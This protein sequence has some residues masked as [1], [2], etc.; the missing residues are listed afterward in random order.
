MGDTCCAC[1]CPMCYNFLAVKASGNFFLYW[2]LF[3]IYRMFYSLFILSFSHFVK[4]WIDRM[5]HSHLLVSHR[6]VLCARKR[7]RKTRHSGKRPD[8]YS[9]NSFYSPIYFIFF[10]FKGSA[11]DDFCTIY[12]KFKWFSNKICKLYL[13]DFWFQLI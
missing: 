6:V 5:C 10:T 13:F 9:Y 1:C 7:A 12:C 4:R 8:N 3:W 11:I 2:C